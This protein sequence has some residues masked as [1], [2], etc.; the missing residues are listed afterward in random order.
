MVSLVSNVRPGPAPVLEKPLDLGLVRAWSYSTLSVFDEC[1]YRVYIQKVKK[2]PEPQGDAAARGEIVHKAAED[3]VSGKVAELIPELKNHSD[4]LLELRELFKAGKVEQEGEWAFT[5]DWTKTDWMAG[6]CWARIKLDA[7]VKESD[8]SCRVIDFKTGKKFGNEIKHAQQGL[9]YAIA[10]FMRDPEMQ[11]ASVEFWYTDLNPKEST[12][13]FYTRE[14]ALMFM[15]GFHNRG[16]KMT[17]EKD[18]NPNPSKMN[19]KW[20]H[21]KKGETPE[22]RYGVT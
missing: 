10:A 9:L 6:D 13:K 19:C 16:V 22:C 3:Y 17:T 20:C 2:I 14:Q 21:F 12:K 11:A 8:T 5:I 7:Y 1:A 4:R 15:P 18:F